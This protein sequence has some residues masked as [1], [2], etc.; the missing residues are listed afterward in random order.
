[1]YFGH[2]HLP[3]PTH[4]ISTPFP[5]ASLSTQLWVFF[6]SCSVQSSLGDPVP[7]GMASALECGWPSRGYIVKENQLPVSQK[8]LNTNSSSANGGSWCPPPPR[9]TRRCCLA[10][11]HCS[12]CAC[13]HNCCEL[14]RAS[15]LLCPPNPVFLMLATIVSNNLSSSPAKKKPEPQEEGGVLRAFPARALHSAVSCFL[16]VDQLRVRSFF[17]WQLRGD[18]EAVF[19]VPESL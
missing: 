10:C 15:A 19:L 18:S 1:M 3:A 16:C 14:K 17:W 7:L 11:I 2:S 8:P 12:R 5:L 9:H 4:S 6:L 13:V